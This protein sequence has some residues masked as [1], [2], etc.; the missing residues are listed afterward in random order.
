MAGITYELESHEVDQALA[1]LEAFAANPQP[2]LAEIGEI[3]LSQGQDSFENQAAP[4]GTPWIPSQRVEQHGGQTLVDKGQ[5]LASLGMEVLPD[6]VMVGTNK[7]YAA[8]HQVGGKAGRGG[9]TTLP[10]RPFLPDE[11]TVDWAEINRAIKA[12][13]A[14]VLG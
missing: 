9:K 10:A 3:V 2:L 14:E 8:I 1:S 5:L 6:S 11:H 7:V 12:H 13:L 4:D